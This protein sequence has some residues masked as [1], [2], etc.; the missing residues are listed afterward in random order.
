[1]DELSHGH[2]NIMDILM[3]GHNNVNLTVT[4]RSER[5]RDIYAPA[6]HG[7][8][9]IVKGTIQEKKDDKTFLK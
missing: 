8:V 3:T 7:Q 6:N 4:G 9:G 1:M 2:K 5:G